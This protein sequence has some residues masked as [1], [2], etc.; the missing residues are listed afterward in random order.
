MVFQRGGV[1]A[2]PSSRLI[3]EG[4]LR[5]DISFSLS[6]EGTLLSNPGTSR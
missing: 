6:Y 4:P 5:D 2:Q 1:F 3:G